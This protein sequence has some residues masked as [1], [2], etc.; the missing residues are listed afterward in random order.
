MVRKVFAILVVFAFAALTGC[1]S[2]TTATSGASGSE[3][4]VVSPSPDKGGPIIDQP[5]VETTVRI[6]GK[7]WTCAQ[8]T[9]SM[10]QDCGVQTQKVFDTYKENIDTYVRGGKLGPLNNGDTFLYEDAA[11]AG[12]VACAFLMNQRPEDAENAY[13]DFMMKTPPFSTTLTE[14][15]MYLPAWFEAPKSLCT[16]SQSGFQSHDLRVP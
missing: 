11:F 4:P 15:V 10:P 16:D 1:S 14:R 8:I 3:T 7:D 5:P 2:N 9:A 12:L 13:I 6:D